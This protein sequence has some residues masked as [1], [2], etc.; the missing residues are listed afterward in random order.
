MFLGRSPSAFITSALALEWLE[1]VFIPST[2]PVCGSASSSASVP[3]N[4]WRI[5][6]LDGHSSHRSEEFIAK[7]YR[8]HACLVFFP[9]HATHLIQPLDRGVFKA[10]KGSFK[11]LMLRESLE[12]SRYLH[13]SI[14]RFYEI[15]LEARREAL[16]PAICNSAFVHSGMWPIDPSRAI[17]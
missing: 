14:A 6:L 17:T 13:V 7:A 11:K 1:R 3:R 15:L 10:I 9:S 2:W 5:L 8:N 16:T 4:P 12:N